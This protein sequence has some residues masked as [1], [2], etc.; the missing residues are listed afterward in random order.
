M[1]YMGLT[2]FGHPM[3]CAAGVATIDVYKDEN[4]I[5]HSAELGVVLG[6]ALEEIRRKHAS[7]GDIRYI[8]LFSVIELVK[9]RKSKERMD[10]GVMN[11]VKGQMQSEGLTTFVSKNMI[12]IVPP[13]V[14]SKTELMD[15]L[16]I[17]E[18]AL[19]IADKA[20]K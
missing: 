15:G 3:S 7:V 10:V 18:R 16:D 1:L 9:D 13:L 4:L 8:G 5:D 20:C 14:I 19:F 12:F 17:I 6:D 11:Q 2:Y